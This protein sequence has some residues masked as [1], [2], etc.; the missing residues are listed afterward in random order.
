M[1]SSQKQ[2]FWQTIALFHDVGVLEYIVVVGSWAEYLYQE[3]GLIPGFQSSF[4]TQDFDVLLRNI[5]LPNRSVD[6][7][8]EF[9]RHGYLMMQNPQ[10]GLMK[11]DKGGELE[12]EFLVREMG[13]GQLAPYRHEYLGVTAQGL[14]YIDILS[15]NSTVLQLR[16]YLIR[17]PRPQAYILHKLLINKQRSATKQEK[18]IGAVRDLLAAVSEYPAELSVLQELFDALPKKAQARIKDTCV[19]NAIHWDKWG[20]T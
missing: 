4:R 9:T 13:K 12:I 6:L 19:K 3:A 1:E 20:K 15:E 7:V 16:G 5:R 11:F 2:T 8:A 17:V 14:R 18:D 10:T